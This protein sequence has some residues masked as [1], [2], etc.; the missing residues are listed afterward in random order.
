MVFETVS[1]SWG[2]VYARYPAVP[3][4][5]GKPLLTTGSVYWGTAFGPVLGRPSLAGQFPPKLAAVN[6]KATR[7]R[8][9]RT[10]LK[11]LGEKMCVSL[12]ARLCTSMS[13]FRLAAIGLG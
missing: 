5:L 1:V 13:S 3:L 11:R 7:V 12:T 4:K 8:P 10:V 2:P 9:A 6:G